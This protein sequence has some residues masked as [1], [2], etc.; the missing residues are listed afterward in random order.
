MYIYILYITVES[1]AMT[2]YQIACMHTSCKFHFGIFGQI[3]SQHVF[4]RDG[5]DWSRQP[6]TLRVYHHTHNITA[7]PSNQSI[8]NQSKVK[9]MT[10]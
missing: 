1:V 7:S 8:M 3:P 2:M 6:L 4:Q 9:L 5:V 10:D